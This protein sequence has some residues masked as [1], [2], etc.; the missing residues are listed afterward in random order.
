MTLSEAADKF[1][2]W[3]GIDAGDTNRLPTQTRYDILN[4]VMLDYSKLFDSRYNETS[5]SLS[6][7]TT[8]STV[9]K[10]TDFGRPYWIYITESDG[11]RSYFEWK[12]TLED[13]ESDDTYLR[14]GDP[15][16]P[17]IITSFGDYFHFLPV[18]DGN[19][20]ATC[21]YYSLAAALT[22]GQTNEWLTHVPNLIIFKALAEYGPLYAI[23]MDPSR[24]G[25][26]KMK[27]DEL[28]RLHLIQ[29][30]RERTAGR[31]PQSAE[32]A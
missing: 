30:T 27:A 16:Q 24:M 6:I 31:R 13:L 26:F 2:A 22:S 1:C 25:M 20:T 23:E 29:S 7:T 5:A 19:Y 28:E 18:A 14:G 15:G 10:P 11:T 32:P 4:W 3:L 8:S 21:V 9:A 17:S 12:A